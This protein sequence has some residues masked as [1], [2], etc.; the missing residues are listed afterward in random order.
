MTTDYFM[1]YSS[2]KYQGCHLFCSINILYESVIF[3]KKIGHILS[4]HK[5]EIICRM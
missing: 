4:L 5:I 3:Y 1:E 2:V